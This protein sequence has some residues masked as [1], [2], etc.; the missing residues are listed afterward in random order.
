MST[1]TVVERPGASP[2]T[3]ARIAGFFYFLLLVVGVPNL[4]VDSKLALK[5]DAAVTAANILSHSSL[6]QL[7]FALNLM[8]PVCYLV[9]TALFYRLFNPVNKTVS[10]VAAFFSLI[11][12]ALAAVGSTL[13]LASSFVL[14]PVPASGFTADQLHGLAQTLIKFRG[15]ALTAN[16]PFF[17][18]FCLLI[19]YLIFKSTFL[20]RLLGVLMMIAGLGWM[21]FFAP[22][23]ASALVP[24]TILPGIGELLLTVWLIVKGVDSGRWYEQADLAAGRRL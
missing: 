18:C 14:S 12:C 23:F 19:G 21:V 11:G 22:L 1:T 3:V 7:D 5:G 20:P 15:V 9:V 4:L 8:S 16:L 6:F 24:Y 13:F 17:G 10:L 2:R